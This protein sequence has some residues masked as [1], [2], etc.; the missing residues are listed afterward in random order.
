MKIK[1]F[2]LIELMAVV[3]IIAILSGIVV[4]GIN[5]WKNDANLKKTI[6]YS[7][8]VKNKLGSSLLAEWKM[9][10]SSGTKIYDSGRLGN[11]GNSANTTR[12]SSGCPEGKYCQ[13]FNG[14]SSIIT[15]NNLNK[16]KFKAVCF[17]IQT[18]QSTA[19]IMGKR[20]GASEGYGDFDIFLSGGLPAIIS[21]SALNVPSTTRVATGNSISDNNWHFVC[22]S[23]DNSSN[24]YFIIDGEVRGSGA[25]NVSNFG[26]GSYPFY[27][28]KN[29]ETGVFGSFIMDDLMLFEDSIIK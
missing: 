1:S 10:E 27:V 6:A 18:T 5:D 3:S 20:S 24:I 4:Y 26:G 28:G 13:S 23:L 16:I 14:S 22:Y 29:Q 8:E 9:E 11:E 2:T 15:T 25:L 19:Q 7:N 21:Y 12:V 17:W